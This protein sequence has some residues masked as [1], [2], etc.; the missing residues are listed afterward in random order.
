[1]VKKVKI[2]ELV[3]SYIY[4]YGTTPIRPQLWNGITEPRA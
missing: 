2:D 4:I 3:L 1:M